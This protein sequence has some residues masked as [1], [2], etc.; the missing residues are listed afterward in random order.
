M[1]AA[2]GRS[3]GSD[4]RLRLHDTEGKLAVSSAGRR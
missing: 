2:H 1:R 4:L 3:V